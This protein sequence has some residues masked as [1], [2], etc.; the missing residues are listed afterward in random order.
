MTY[1]DN[2]DA[3]TATVKIIGTGD[4]NKSVTKTFVIKPADISKA[5]VVLRGTS[6][7]YTGEA[8]TPA[9]DRLGVPNG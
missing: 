5:S 4:Y 8:I 6:F 7:T 9:G 2:I 1:T 3:G